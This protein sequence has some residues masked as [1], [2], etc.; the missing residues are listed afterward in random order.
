M[1]NRLRGD[2]M[3]EEIITV[4]DQPAVKG[5]LALHAKGL[6]RLLLKGVVR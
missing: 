4:A 3:E 1:T 5:P 6:Q 2:L